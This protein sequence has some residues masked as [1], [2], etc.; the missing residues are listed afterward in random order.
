MTDLGTQAEVA[1]WIVSACAWHGRGWV[2]VSWCG[3]MGFSSARGA[4]PCRCVDPGAA[5]WAAPITLVLTVMSPLLWIVVSFCARHTLGARRPSTPF[6]HGVLNKLGW[7]LVVVLLP[8][9]VL[10][11]SLRIKNQS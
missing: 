6:H 4:M 5:T 3:S 1:T 7:Y 10:N 2:M 8:T 11:K 9:G